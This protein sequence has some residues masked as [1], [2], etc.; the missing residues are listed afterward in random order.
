MLSGLG[1]FLI[2]VLTRFNRSQERGPW[3]HRIPGQERETAGG[4]RAYNLAYADIRIQMFEMWGEVR[5][6]RPERGR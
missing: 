5:A 3:S 1:V 2:Q 4:G 6:H